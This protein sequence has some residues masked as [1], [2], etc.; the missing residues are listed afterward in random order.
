MA[1]AAPMAVA[2]DPA[3]LI[4]TRPKVALARRRHDD[5]RASESRA[6]RVMPSSEPPRHG[7]PAAQ[8][9]GAAQLAPIGGSV[10]DRVDSSA[11]VRARRDSEE[12]ERGVENV[13]VDH[14][15]EEQIDRVV[16]GA[17]SRSTRSTLRLRPP[18]RQQ[19]ASWPTP[20]SASQVA[21]AC[22]CRFW[23]RRRDRG[24]YVD[25][26]RRSASIVEA[27]L[28]TS[29]SHTLSAPYATAR[30]GP[31][32]LPSGSSRMT[33]CSSDASVT[34]TPDR[35]MRASELVVIA[36]GT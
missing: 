15:V 8:R 35:P 31:C 23:A 26:G 24:A 11:S 21:I 20:G 16:L 7:R 5:S 32:R 14:R 19:L 6:Q 18:R 34:A 36:R 25:G 2:A 17:S 27:S 33:V 22:C 1:P 30:G 12:L 29:S 4:S 9:L 28:A 3:P 10:G 13:L